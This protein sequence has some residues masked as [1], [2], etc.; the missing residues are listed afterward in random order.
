MFQFKLL[1]Q[2][3]CSGDTSKWIG[4]ENDQFST[5]LSRELSKDSSKELVQA[6][7]MLFISQGLQSGLW[8]QFSKFV[9]GP[10]E[11]CVTKAILDIPIFKSFHMFEIAS[12]QLNIVY[13]SFVSRTLKPKC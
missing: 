12:D 6:F 5:E 2:S 10:S 1:T 4:Y 13:D 7:V 3:W 11:S 8:S 9:T